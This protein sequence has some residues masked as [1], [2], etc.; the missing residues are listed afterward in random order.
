MEDC[1]CSPEKSL[2]STCGYVSSVRDH[3]LRTYPWVT[4][5]I[6]T[7]ML[8]KILP[9]ILL[10]VLNILMILGYKEALHRRH[11]MSSCRKIINENEDNKRSTN[12]QKLTIKWEPSVTGSSV[13]NC[14]GDSKTS[15][16][17]TSLTR[18][19]KRR[20]AFNKKE[21]NLIN[22][23]M[24]LGCVFFITNIPIA[25]AKILLAFG[26]SKEKYFE[27]FIVI[28]NI[29][30]VFF[31]ASN[32]YLYCLFNVQVRQKVSILSQDRNDINFFC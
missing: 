7:E 22:L 3:L 8:A 1:G 28:S 13:T 25:I 26:F 18:Q 17:K 23:L 12:G 24:L 32:F 14:N 21:K 10:V 2:N 16:R 27:E 6:L 20:S 30:E 4:F 31:A 11:M 29:L 15:E 5:V 9:A 19:Q